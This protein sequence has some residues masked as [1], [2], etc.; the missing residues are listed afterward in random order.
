VGRLAVTDDSADS[1]AAAV[2]FD[3]DIDL[4]LDLLVDAANKHVIYETR[5]G[6]NWQSFT[7]VNKF[8]GVLFQT[9]LFHLN[10]ELSTTDPHSKRNHILQ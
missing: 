10:K 9:N 7:V 6:R 4:L 1:E 3:P 8:Y 5:F 2:D